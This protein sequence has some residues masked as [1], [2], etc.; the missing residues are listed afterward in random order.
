MKKP[1]S[2]LHVLKF[3]NNVSKSQQ[4]LVDRASFYDPSSS[5][6]CNTCCFILHRHL[7]TLQ[8]SAGGGI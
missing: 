6:A 4:A 7:K 5:C 2:L 8:Y 3:I 1:T